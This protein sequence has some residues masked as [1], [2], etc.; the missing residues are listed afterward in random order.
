MWVH[1]VHQ[2]PPRSPMLW[3]ISA[4][5]LLLEWNINRVGKAAIKLIFNRSQ[6][7]TFPCTRVCAP[8]CTGRGWGALQRFNITVVTPAVSLP[9]GEKRER[10]L[11]TTD[12]HAHTLQKRFL[13]EEWSVGADG[14]RP[15]HSSWNYLFEWLNLWEW[16]KLNSP[17]HTWSQTNREEDWGTANHQGVQFI[18]VYSTSHTVTECQSS[19]PL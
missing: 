10:G 13:F 17:G 1:P 4:M 7:I 9:S 16:N 8:L 11:P 3:A 19:T 18:P 6:L 15:L 14:R 5:A 12:I 2:R